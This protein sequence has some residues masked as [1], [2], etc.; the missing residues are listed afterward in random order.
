[1]LT[2]DYR[3]R[4]HIALPP[5]PGLVLG[6]KGSEH[7][8]AARLDAANLSLIWFRC[9]L[10]KIQGAGVTLSVT[11]DVDHSV[12]PSRVLQER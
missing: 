12:A 5:I 3:K 7:P 9:D 11:I 1:M 6:I 4:R 8:S 10:A 2:L